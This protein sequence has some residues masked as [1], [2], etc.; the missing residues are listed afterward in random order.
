MLT[1]ELVSLQRCLTLFTDALPKLSRF[2]QAQARR[3]RGLLVA[4][5]YGTWYA[6]VEWGRLAWSYRYD[7]FDGHLR[8]WRVGWLYVECT[9]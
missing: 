1:C 3:L 8:S 9:F 5:R 7:Y 4:A 2:F 6:G